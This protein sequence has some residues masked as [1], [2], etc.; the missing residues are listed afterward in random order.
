ME[1]T[2]WALSDPGTTRENNED[3]IY[4]AVAETPAGKA[5]FG[6][7]CDGMGG[8]DFGEVASGT[9][10]RLFSDWFGSSLAQVEDIAGA[11]AAVGKWKSLISRANAE[12]N[13]ICAE[14]GAVLG[15]TLTA[16]LLIGGRYFTAQIGDSRAYAVSGGKLRRLTEDHS[17]VMEMVAQGRMTAEEA[18]MSA[19]KNI[20][21]RCIGARHDYCA[22]FSSGEASPGDLFLL[23]SDGFHGGLDDGR[24]M[25]LIK[26]SFGGDIQ[27]MVRKAVEAKKAMGEKDNISLIAAAVW[28][29]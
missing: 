3:C 27:S 24:M 20:L 5:F 22:D 8:L 23:C 12:I 14:R 29:Q 9:A 10:V 26:G 21:T 18:V 17:Y 25:E 4:A 2:I 15:T 11:E 19:N 28:G 13:A 6:V 1:Y 7:V 16:L